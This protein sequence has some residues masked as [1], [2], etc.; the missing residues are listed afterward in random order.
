[1][2]AS[3]IGKIPLTLITGFLG[4]G[5]TTLVSALL[6]QEDMRQVAVVVNEMGEIG[7]D[8]ELISYSSENIS[9][10]ANGCICCSVRT[11]LQE[12][13]R[14]LFAQKRAGQVLD[15][16]RVVVE[17]TGLADPAPVMQTLFSDTLLAAQFRLDGVITLVDAVLGGETLDA[18]PEAVKQVMM[19]DALLLTKCDLAS[20]QQIQASQLKIQGLRPQLPC[21]LIK[22]GLIPASELLGLGL[23]SSRNVQSNLRF[24]GTLIDSDAIGTEPALA[25]QWRAAHTPFQTHTLR[26]E[27]AMSWETFSEALDLLTRLRGKDLLRMKGIINVDGEPLVVQGVQH[28]MQEPVRLDAWPSADLSS[29]LVFI[30]RGIDSNAIRRVFEAIETLTPEQAPGATSETS[31]REKETT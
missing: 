1:M 6:R 30:T 17:T 9:L 12:T 29:R 31:S 5:K 3:L 27:R 19:A 23:S 18:H 2:R 28:L 25:Q 15:F 16:D 21:K 24:L 14:E 13:L 4:S 22:N 26:F 20:P 10:L 7:I 8:H 11:D